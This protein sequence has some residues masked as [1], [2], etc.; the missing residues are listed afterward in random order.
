MLPS[1]YVYLG[2]ANPTILTDLGLFLLN[3][4]RTFI[5]LQTIVSLFLV[6]DRDLFVGVTAT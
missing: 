5:F 3:E 1:R 6:L 4:V 2:T